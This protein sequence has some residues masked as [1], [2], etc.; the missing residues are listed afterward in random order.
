MGTVD[1]VKLAQV[2]PPQGQGQRV[3]HLAVRDSVELHGC[4]PQ[5][6]FTAKRNENRPS[7]GPTPNLE[8]TLSREMGGVVLTYSHREEKHAY[9]IPLSNVRAVKLDG[10]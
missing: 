4:A 6:T 9:L 5:T 10:L 2:T 3:T 8:M 7:I 1:A